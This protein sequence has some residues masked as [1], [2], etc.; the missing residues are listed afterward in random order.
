[1]I[2][3]WVRAPWIGLIVF[4]ACSSAPAPSAEPA[5]RDD[6][7]PR[8]ARAEVPDGASHGPSSSRAADLDHMIAVRD[9]LRLVA[10]SRDRGRALLA[11]EQPVAHA[12][13]LRVVDIDT[14]STIARVEMFALARL[15]RRPFLDEDPT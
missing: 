13:E 9:R 4:G 8:D 14:G 10:L 11:V 2:D 6:A 3:P 12:S 1:M 7:A 15:P 5:T